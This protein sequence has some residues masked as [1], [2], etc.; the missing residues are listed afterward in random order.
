MCMNMPD[1]K[2]INN[3]KITEKYIK[4]H[5]PEFY[6]YLID[7]YPSDLSFSEKIYWYAHKIKDYP[8]CQYCKE[9]RVG[10]EGF[11]HGY[12]KFCSQKCVNNDPDKL[13]RIKNIDHSYKA[14]KKNNTKKEPRPDIP[15]LESLNCNT[16]TEKSIKIFYPKFYELLMSNYPADLKFTE[17]IYW[18]YHGIVDYP[19]C[20]QCKV[21][22]TKFDGF[23]RGYRTYCSIKCS[24]ESETK[25]EKVEQT[26][27]ERYGCKAPAQ[28]EEIKKKTREICLEKYGVENP[29]QLPE[30]K[31][32]N[33]ET[34]MRL[35]GGFGMASEISRKKYEETCLEKYGTIYPSQTKKLIDKTK[36]TNLERYGYTC[37]MNRPEIREKSKQ[38]LK[39]KSKESHPLLIDYTD[40]DNW[41]CKCPHSE[42]TK[43]K[44]K[45]YYTRRSIQLDRERDKTELCTR[46]L[47]IGD[48]GTKNTSIEIFVR[49]ILDEL[50]IEYITNDRTILK[51]KEL[52]I[53]IPSK[54]IAIEC[55]GVYSHSTLYKSTSYHIDKFKSCRSQGIQLL[56]LWEDWI[57]SKP[58]IIRS[59]IR[60]KFGVF[61]RRIG[62][63]KCKIKEINST[64]TN[65]FLINNHIQGTTSHRVAYG[66][67]EKEELVA[68]M[69]FGR[70]KALGGNHEKEDNQWELSRFCTKQDLQV[71]GGAEKLLKY[72]IKMYNPKSIVSFSAN[73]IS[74][75]NLY[76]KLG[77]ETNNSISNSYWYIDPVDMIR[78]H[79]LTFSKSSIVRYGW[80]DKI[81]DSWTENQ[82]M[83]EHG[84]LRIY[85]SG[86][87]KWI[88]N[89]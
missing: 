73:D 66:L 70:K 37:N 54:N 23:I 27:L 24:N 32:K 71:I 61:D 57:K 3:C 26:N 47:P 50:G 55:N 17:R 65:T 44:E 68:V 81:D 31:L 67:Y 38:A 18:Y 83:Y 19:C 6:Q 40:V 4:R 29:L 87:T 15:E 77:F 76:R 85:D 52:D 33:A 46:L 34:H 88:L 7:N 89:L 20:E 5:Y 60:S 39:N 35:Y 69:T 78:Y 82:V 11:F 16:A 49:N 58:E 59:I 36:Q 56:S 48:D 25:R 79:R 62:A 1:F 74:N 8:V 41:I 14:K 2:H 45:V 86:I 12:R 42:C 43:C 13:E 64:V 84:Y 9:N 21:K 80:K 63:S 28:S 10:Y 22:R 51:P 30:F 75:G 53:Y 72:F